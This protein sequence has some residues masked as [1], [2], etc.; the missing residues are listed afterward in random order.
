M[1]FQGMSTI[2]TS[3]ARASRN[4]RNWRRPN[5]DSHDAIGVRDPRRIRASASGSKQSISSHM[6]R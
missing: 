3:I 1:P 6:S 5:S 4:G 2:A